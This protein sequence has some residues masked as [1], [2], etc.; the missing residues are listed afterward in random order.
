[1]QPPPLAGQL[2]GQLPHLQPM[3]LLI[4]CSR[5]A[6]NRGRG[7][8]QAPSANIWKGNLED[9]I[10]SDHVVSDHVHQMASPGVWAAKCTLDSLDGEGLGN[11]GVGGQ[12]R[13]LGDLPGRAQGM[14]ILP[15]GLDGD[16]TSRINTS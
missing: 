4:A 14:S 3:Q 11:L 13:W 6:A 8:Q 12:G 16:D 15:M 1:M 7:S 2:N 9:Q 5:S 10:R